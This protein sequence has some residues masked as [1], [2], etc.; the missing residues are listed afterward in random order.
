MRLHDNRKD[1]NFIEAAYPAVAV[2]SMNHLP[3]GAPPVEE[4]PNEPKKPPVK[5]PGDPHEKPPFPEIPPMEDPGNAPF[6]PPVKEPPPEDPNRRPPHPPTMRLM[7][8]LSY[9]NTVHHP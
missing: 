2:F 4:P 7:H 1:K 3:P 9:Q 6:D 5:E 8:T